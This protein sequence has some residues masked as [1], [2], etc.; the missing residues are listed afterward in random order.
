MKKLIYLFLFSVVAISC[1]R[2]D[3]GYEGILIKQYGA[4]K[5]VSDVTLVTGRVSYNPFT[6]D[7]EQVPLFVQTV[8]YE[9]F[10][11]NDKDGS[12]FTVDPTL[13]IKVI[14]GKSPAIYQKYRRDVEDIVQTTIL[15]YI[16]CLPLTIQ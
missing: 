2:I 11:V 3:A 10:T 12:V 4:D 5:G 9:P 7:V 6:E 16:R 1:T 13:S 8:D 15:N 14:A